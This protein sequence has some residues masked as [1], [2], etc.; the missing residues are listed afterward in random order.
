[1][2]TDGRRIAGKATERSVSYERSLLPWRDKEWA[3]VSK[4]R[5]R[6]SVGS[7]D[8]TLQHRFE[9]SRAAG[10]PSATHHSSLTPWRYV[11]YIVTVHSVFSYH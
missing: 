9:Y 2:P 8:S 4:Q 3:E 5:R 1:M 10:E 6:K 11:R 7:E